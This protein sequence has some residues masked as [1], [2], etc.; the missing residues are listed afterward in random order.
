MRLFRALVVSVATGVAWTARGPSCRGVPHVRAGPMPADMR[1]LVDS[2]HLV[3]PTESLI[4]LCGGMDRTC[5]EKKLEEIVVV[6]MSRCYLINLG[7]LTRCQALM[8]CILPGN[9]ITKI[10]ALSYCPNLIKLDLHGNHIT[11]LPGESF[12]SDM[13]CLQVLYLHNNIIGDANDIE[14]LCACPR[15]TVLTLSDTPV[16]LLPNY[17]HFIVNNIWS[18]KALDNFVI[19]DE[20]VMEDWPRNERFKALNPEFLLEVPAVSQTSTWCN[21]M[22]NIR[23]LMAT[24]NTILAHHSPVHIIQRWIRGHITRKKLSRL[25]PGQHCEPCGEVNMCGQGIHRLEDGSLWVENGSSR[26]HGRCRAVQ[27]RIN[28]LQVKM[29]EARYKA[30]DITSGVYPHIL[31]RKGW[32]TKLQGG[33]PVTIQAM[34]QPNVIPQGELESWMEEEE[35]REEVLRLG[36]ILHQPA[37]ARGVLLSKWAAGEDIRLGVRQLHEMVQKKPRPRFAYQPPV[38]LG[39]RLFAKSLGCVTLAPFIAI[40]KAYSDREKGAMQRI[41]T[42]WARGLRVA[43]GQARVCLHGMA[44]RRNLDTA[45]RHKEDQAHGDRVRQ[46]REAERTESLR[47]AR[48]NNALFLEEKRQR[49]LE[50][51]ST[52]QFNTHYTMMAEA[53]LKKQIKEKE[54]NLHQQNADRARSIKMQACQMKGEI[55][56]FMVFRRLAMQAESKAARTAASTILSQATKDRLQYARARVAV[57]RGRAL[58]VEAPEEATDAGFPWTKPTH[59]ETPPS[60]T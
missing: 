57:Q 26:Y 5:K 18:L 1:R 13:R 8:I 7:D 45:R 35:G 23:K 9:Y 27:L 39:K 15:L 32:N 25:D 49:A 6:N 52:R 10:D 48:Q 44:V 2:T 34:P 33:S 11:E 14:A 37:C 38:S 20:E 51:E 4:L 21:E 16:S 24:V 42:D 41:R 17:R 47:L 46:Q 29:L 50:R 56:D 36:P 30:K 55:T 31:Q 12:W 3:S 54:E 19:A 28:E 53:L 43:E 40:Q 22:E 59:C 60:E 58:M